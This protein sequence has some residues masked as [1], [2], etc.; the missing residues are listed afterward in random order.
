MHAN[1]ADLQFGNVSACSTPADYEEAMREVNNLL[2]MGEWSVQQCDCEHEC[3]QTTYQAY[4]ENM[5]FRPNETRLRIFY[6]VYNK[7]HEI[8]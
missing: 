3:F 6:E 1:V 7:I 2:F 8:V 5:V 4:P